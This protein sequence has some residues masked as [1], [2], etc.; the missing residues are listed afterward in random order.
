VRRALFVAHALG[1]WRDR[2]ALVM[3]FV[4]PVMV[5][6]I[7]AAIFGG[8]TGEQLR[9]RVALADEADTALSRRLIDAVRLSPTL[10]I[11]AEGRGRA[12]VER[13]VA[14]GAA[15]VGLVVPRDARALDQ[16]IGDDPAPLVVVTHPARRVAGALLSG[17]VQ[18]LYFAQL[19]DAALG[20]VV[21]LVDEAIVPLTDEQRVEASGQIAALRPSADGEAET[22]A[23]FD[24]LVAEQVLA[25]SGMAVDQVAYYAGAVAA[26]FVLLSGVVGASGLHDDLDSGLVERLLA[27]PGGIGTMV[28]SRM[29]FLTL[30]GT[31]QISIIFAIAWA[32]YGVSLAGRVFP[33][34][35]VTVALAVCAAGL[36]VLVAT[37]CRTA[38]QS[39]TVGNVV[40]LVLSAA[41][42][43]MVPRFL[44]PPWLQQAGVATP[45]AW[46]LDGYARALEAAP[47]W[48][49][50][51]EAAG[52][53]SAAGVVCWIVGRRCARRWE[54]V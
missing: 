45:N 9:L 22:V 7:F 21:Q 28:D 43:S 35:L 48:P 47:R 17:A 25:G 27:G 6:T 12:V 4:L 1:L 52:V 19:P 15:D 23:A 54:V 49:G 51:I 46:A 24:T 44:M 32:I 36:V 5:F 40:T 3:S 20:A 33:W 2:G 31:V 38:R 30:Q 13:D 29:A 41:G 14:S 34:A 53:L 8:A 26:M 50:V 18:R 37:L 16:L 39:H 11:V 10:R 42:G